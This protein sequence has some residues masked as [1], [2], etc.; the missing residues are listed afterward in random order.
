M[1]ELDREGG[2]LKHCNK[3]GTLKPVSEFHKNARRYDGLQSQ[4]KPCLNAHKKS[5]NAK[6]T[7]RAYYVRNKEAI[8]S[9][10]S[11]YKKNNRELH[12]I[13]ARA[14]FK[15]TGNTAKALARLRAYQARKRKALPGWA[16]LCAIERIYS[17]CAALRWLTKQPWE[18]DHIVPLKSDVVCGLHVEANLQ[19]L[20][21]ADNA[22]K[23]N[24]HW[25]DMP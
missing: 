17:I 6:R 7:E 3:C 23:S 11:A 13:Q 16:D 25:P 14:A 4:C 12:N 24:R 8:R 20:S 1:L 22:A 19:I 2:Y 21:K 10:A 5:D 18:V 15:R 9:R